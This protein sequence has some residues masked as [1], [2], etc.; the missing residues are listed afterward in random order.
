[1][2]LLTIA[3]SSHPMTART[4]M[5]D[6]GTIGREKTL[7]VAWGLESLH[8]SLA[9]ACRLV[10]VLCTIIEIPVLAMFHTREY[11]ALGGSVAFEFIGDDHTWDVG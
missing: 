6:D 9:L 4:E 7:S 3:G 1:M 8:A 10:R 11:L 5:L 2:H